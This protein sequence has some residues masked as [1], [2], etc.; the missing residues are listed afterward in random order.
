LRRGDIVVGAS[1]G[2][3][4]KPRPVLVV[5]SDAL[6]DTHP[7]IVV[8]PLTSELRELSYRIPVEPGEASGLREPSEIMVDKVQAVRRDKVRQTIGRVT[9]QTLEAVDRTLTIILGLGEQPAQP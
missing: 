2:D 4:G 8:C 3:F 5:Q 7:S 6:N 1:D 9:P